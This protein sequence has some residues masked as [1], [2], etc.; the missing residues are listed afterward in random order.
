MYA[1]VYY[2]DKPVLYDIDT[3]VD[4]PADGFNYN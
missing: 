2:R 4:I 3:I 1:N